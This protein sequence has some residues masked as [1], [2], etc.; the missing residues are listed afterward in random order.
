LRWNAVI[1]ESFA[2]QGRDKPARQLFDLVLGVEP[3]QVDALRG[4]SALGART[5]SS[6]QA[7]VDAQRLVSVSPDSGEDRLL[8]ARAY[9]AGGNS[10]D[11]RR[12][13]WEAF[14]AIPDD[15]RVLAALK[16]MLVSA[17]DL[18][19]ERRLSEEYADRQ[20]TRLNKELV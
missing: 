6:K 20:Q 2:L 15:E 4:R 10:A 12:T 16:N 19:A 7:I 9:L 3:D 11:A 13:L 18:D 8:L 5:G 17:G 14:Q 1:A